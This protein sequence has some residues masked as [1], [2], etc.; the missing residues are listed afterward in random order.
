MPCDN[1]A[2]TVEIAAV[3]GSGNPDSILLQ[4]FHAVVAWQPTSYLCGPNGALGV[5][6]LLALGRAASQWFGRGQLAVQVGST[7]HA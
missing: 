4:S 7:S 1:S 2:Q 5:V 3:P 6:V